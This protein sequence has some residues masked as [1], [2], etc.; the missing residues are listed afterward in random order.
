MLVTTEILTSNASLLRVPIRQKVK[1][2]GWLKFEL[3]HYLELKGMKHV[4]VES[5]REYG[6]DR[7]DIAFFGNGQPY[8]LE[9][10]TPNTNWKLRGVNENGR[11]ITKNV[12]SIIDDAKKLNSESGIV[13]FVLF[14]VP[15]GDGRWE[16][17]LDRINKETGLSVTKD[18]NCE[19]ISLN[20]DEDSTCDLIVCAFKSR[21]FHNWSL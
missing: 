5:K 4:E 15:V 7:A 19:I 12:Q 3:A 2:E 10:K 14:P 8:R 18:G 16:P 20:I 21:R 13:A 6:R 1:F 17:Y 11:P 9:L